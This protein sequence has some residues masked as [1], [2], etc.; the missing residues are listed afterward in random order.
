MM[1]KKFK[2]TELILLSGKKKRI[3]K[4]DCVDVQ[5]QFVIGGVLTWL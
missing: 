5:E 4:D 2:T 3:I 1:K